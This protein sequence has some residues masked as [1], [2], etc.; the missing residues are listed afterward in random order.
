MIIICLHACGLTA[1][2]HTVDVGQNYNYDRFNQILQ[3]S[4]VVQINQTD[5]T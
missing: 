2:C 4:W 1:Y 5:Y 3:V